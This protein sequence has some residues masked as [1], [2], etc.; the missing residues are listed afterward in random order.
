[1]V[2]RIRDP[3]ELK[4]ALE[5]QLK[6][7]AA[8]CKA[9][10]EGERWEALRLATTIHILVH[11]GGKNNKSLLTQLGIK[12]RVTFIA[13]GRPV[14][15]ENL[16]ADTPMVMLRISSGEHATYL[17]ALEGHADQHRHVTFGEWWER[18]LI[19]RSGDNKHRMTR[20]K[21]TFAL[22]NQDGGAHYDEAVED[23]NY[24]EMTHGKTWISVSADG[25]E[26]P[27]RELELAS[28][29]QVAWE[30]FESLKISGIAI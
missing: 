16:V 24:I 4:M 25:T 27:I 10:D 8:S 18:D 22:R 30:F 14:D 21:L 20:K 1:M 7:L 6:A 26:R 13:S 9:Y 17:P 28:M 15:P 23:P 12:D 5:R 19:F 3:D 29:R 2:K 11:D